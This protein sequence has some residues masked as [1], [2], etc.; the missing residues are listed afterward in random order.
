[1]F[2]VTK[3]YGHDLGLSSCFR[4]PFAD[5][6][7]SEPHGYP[8][9][10]KFTF[11]AGVLDRNNWVI[12]FGGLKPVKQWLCDNFDHRMIL[13][14]TDPA[15]D[16]FR[17]LYQKLG[18]RPINVLPFVGCEGFAQYTF[19][20]VSKWLSETFPLDCQRRHLK[21]DEVEVREHGGNSAIYRR[22]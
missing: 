3:T 22:D 11:G 15:L 5:S 20:H 21:L 16:D 18:F 10:F 13:S 6:H 14:V 7:C 1:M 8:L 9:G 12:D 4:Q 19:S 17:L 2:Y